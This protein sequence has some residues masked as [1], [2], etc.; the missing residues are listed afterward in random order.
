MI[1]WGLWNSI[2]THFTGACFCHTVHLAYSNK[3][4]WI[5]EYIIIAVLTHALSNSSCVEIAE[6]KWNILK[7][8]QKLGI[9]MAILWFLSKLKNVANNV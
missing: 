5:Y 6:L 7:G 9:H 8:I 2:K 3:V 4:V 1:F